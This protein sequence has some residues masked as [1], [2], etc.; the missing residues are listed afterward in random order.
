[1]STFV[2]LAR[3]ARRVSRD[4]GNRAATRAR[5]SREAAFGAVAFSTFTIVVLQ[6]PTALNDLAVAGP[7]VACAYFA[8][9]P[10]ARRPRP[11]GPGSRARRRHEADDGARPAGAHRASCSRRIAAGRGRLSASP[12][13]QGSSEARSGTYVNFVVT[14]KLDGGLSDAFPQIADRS[15]GRRSTGSDGCLVTSSRCPAPKAG[16]GSARRCPACSSALVVA[17]AAGILLLARRSRAQPQR[18]RPR[19]RE[20]P[21]S[22]YPMLATWVDVAGRASRQALVTAHRPPTSPRRARAVAASTRAPIHSAYGIAFLRALHLGWR[23]RRP[24]RRSAAASAR[25]RRRDRIAAAASSS[26]SR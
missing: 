13:S 19:R 10:V 8:I 21:S 14:G 24:R 15:L 9:R 1:M 23:D 16:A 20:S 17:V 11:R 5:A 25:C 26:S 2:Q 22:L 3:V 7:L 18:R 4:R 6:T 12:E